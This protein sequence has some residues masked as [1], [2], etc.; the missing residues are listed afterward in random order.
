MN[1]LNAHQSEN[2]DLSVI[3]E[4]VLSAYYENHQQSEKGTFLVGI[5]GSSGAG[6][7]TLSLEL[8]KMLKQIEPYRVV[9][10]IQA[11]NFIYPNAYLIEHNMMHR[12]G[13]PESFDFNALKHCLQA[14]RENSGLPVWTPCYSQEI[15]DIV[16]EKKSVVDKSDIYLFEGVNLFFSY[17]TFH[18]SDFLDF[19]IY[20]DTKRSIIKERALKR[21]FDAY[22][23]SKITPTPYFEKFSSW[24]EQAIYQHAEMLWEK[25]DMALLE[26]HI[27]PYKSL[28]N[29]V[30]KSYN[31]S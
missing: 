3:A 9:T 4:T 12:K 6:K 23:R 24:T 14:I 7:T 31:A 15:K 20:L 21:F 22:E 13:F 11:D 8:Q 17:E 16:P 19:C 29:L 26:K 27:E 5:T 10:V 1:K 30:L 2:L 28:A 18:P 25:M